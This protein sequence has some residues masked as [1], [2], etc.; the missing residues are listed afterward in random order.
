MCVVRPD[1][2]YYKNVVSK[3]RPPKTKVKSKSRPTGKLAKLVSKVA[4][5]VK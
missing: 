4:K 3:F 1:C 5:V 2:L